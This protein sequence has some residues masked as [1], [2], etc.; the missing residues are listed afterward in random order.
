MKI[1]KF[2]YP[3]IRSQPTPFILWWWVCT[4][5]RKARAEDLSESLLR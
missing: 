4:W 1:P 5:R 2:W 3:H